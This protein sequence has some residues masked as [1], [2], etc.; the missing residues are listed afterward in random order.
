[1]SGAGDLPPRRDAEHGPGCVLGGGF[2]RASSGWWRDGWAARIPRAHHPTCPA[3]RAFR[4][5][6]EG[7]A[8]R[9]ILGGGLASSV[10]PSVLHGH[11]GESGPQFFDG[12]VRQ[13][14]RAE[15]ERLQ[16][17]Q[18]GELSQVGDPRGHAIQ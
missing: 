17:G 11:V 12:L 15:A 13:A 1:M 14:S 16:L 9:E 18:S 8:G 4:T 5:L 3:V 2:A 6:A 7:H 10:L